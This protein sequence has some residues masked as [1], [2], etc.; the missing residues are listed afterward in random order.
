ML[1]DAWL[2]QHA[3]HP[4]F[5]RQTL[6]HQQCHPLVMRFL[7]PD[8]IPGRPSCLI[9]LRFQV[10]QNPQVPEE[11]KYAAQ[12]RFQETYDTCSYNIS[13]WTV[14]ACASP[15]FQ[16]LQPVMEAVAGRLQWG[17]EAGH[18][19]PSTP[20]PQSSSSGKLMEKTVLQVGLQSLRS[21]GRGP[22]HCCFGHQQCLSR[23]VQTDPTR[24]LCTNCQCYVCNR[25]AMIQQ[26]QQHLEVVDKLQGSSCSC[27]QTRKSVSLFAC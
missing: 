14:A 6:P 3:H 25:Q 5:M 15:A 23:R 27:Q 12:Q 26:Q 1:V 2:M 20:G 8:M 10:M 22:H 24:L 18:H 7:G 16:E 17:L 21:S 4:S 11:N 19:Q 13:H 9:G